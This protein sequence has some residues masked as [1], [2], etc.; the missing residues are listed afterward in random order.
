M[1][2]FFLPALLLLSCS[3]LAEDGYDLWL[4]YK[5]I[6]KKLLS[7]YRPQLNEIYIGG[8]SATMDAAKEELANGIHGL[9]NIPVSFSPVIKNNGSTRVVVA[10]THV[11]D[12][13]NL[14]AVLAHAG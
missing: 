8:T 1:K 14:Q 4:R 13:L 10:A 11:I 2:K 6:D 3:I 5:R 9:L 7:L 12:S